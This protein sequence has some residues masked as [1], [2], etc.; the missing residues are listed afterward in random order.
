M[1]TNALTAMQVV[2][3]E[4]ENERVE[5]NRLLG[6]F[7]VQDIPQRPRGQVSITVTFAISADGILDVSASVKEDS[8]RANSI[9]IQQNKVATLF[10]CQSACTIL[11]D[12]RVY[13]IDRACCRRR[14]SPS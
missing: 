11:I 13:P 6:C 3:Y 4:G 2:V 8:Q 9:R 14:R 1:L 5:R 10:A 7:T 12:S